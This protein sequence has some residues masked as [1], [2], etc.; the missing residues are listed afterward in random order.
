MD[1]YL[2]HS[3]V[4][5]LV[6]DHEDDDDQVTKYYPVINRHLVIK[7]DLVI[8]Y[9]L[10]MKSHQLIKHD[11]VIKIYLV[12]KTKEVKTVKEVKRSDS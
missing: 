4:E 10:V 3:G 5:T 12:I 7:R 11:L 9:Y 2:I 8:K 6:I 1:F